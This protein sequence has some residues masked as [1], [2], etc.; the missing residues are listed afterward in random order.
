MFKRIKKLWKKYTSRYNK[1][2]VFKKHYLK[3]LDTMPPEFKPDI[4]Q[5]GKSPYKEYYVQD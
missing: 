4:Q 1:H 3:R 2:V 5:K